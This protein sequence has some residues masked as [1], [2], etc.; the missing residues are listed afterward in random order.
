M[1]GLIFLLPRR[2]VIG[3][4]PFPGSF[5]ESQRRTSSAEACV[6][7]SMLAFAQPF[8]KGPGEYALP[9]FNSLVFALCVAGTMVTSVSAEVLPYRL[10]R[11]GRPLKIVFLFLSNQT[12]IHAGRQ[13]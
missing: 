2:T 8:K 12:V 5:S 11:A 7:R 13:Q 4:D 9:K 3:G 10:V 6:R 1:P